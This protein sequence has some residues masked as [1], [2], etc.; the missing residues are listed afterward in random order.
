MFIFFFQVNKN[1]IKCWGDF[2][3]KYFNVWRVLFHNQSRRQITWNLLLINNIKNSIFFLIKIKKWRVLCTK[4]KPKPVGRNI[5]RKK[6]ETMNC[7]R[8][9][10]IVYYSGKSLLWISLSKINY[11]FAG[12]GIRSFAPSLKSLKSNEQLWANRSG[13]SC[14]K[15]DREWV[16]QV[17]HDNEQPW[18]ICLGRSRKMSEWPNRSFFLSES[19]I[20]SFAH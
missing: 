7:A 4:C 8:I 1:A 12:L 3:N 11:D 2:P 19:L 13:P 17:A 14:Q 9:T 18:V 16:T 10:L 5:W 20:R 15:S 6:L